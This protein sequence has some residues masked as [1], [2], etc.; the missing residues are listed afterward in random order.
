M[1]AS[2]ATAA[3]PKP[4]RGGAPAPNEL[5]SGTVFISPRVVDEEAFEEYADRL[6]SLLDRIRDEASELRT[7]ISESARTLDDLR[8][9]GEKNKQQMELTARLLKA[10][11]QRAPSVPPSA[12]NTQA[13]FSQTVSAAADQLVTAATAR[14]QQLIAS[15]FEEFETQLRAKLGAADAAVMARLAELGAATGRADALLGDS[16]SPHTLTGALAD[17]AHARQ[18]LIDLRTDADR[19]TGRL[20]HT[21]DTSAELIE[22]ATAKQEMIERAL[23][24]SI[25]AA[26][27]AS[28]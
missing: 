8:T 12:A 20:A 28:S 13:G 9:A 24:E 11:T 22:Q 25:R 27:S 16:S 21:L 18:R 4:A 19:A 5:A 17:A 26:L 2:P 3:A 1:S 7:L 14:L 23:R 6:R 15:R 10:A